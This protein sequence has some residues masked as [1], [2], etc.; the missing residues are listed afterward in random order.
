[1]IKKILKKASRLL[2]DK[3]FVGL[4]Y[5]LKFGEKMPWKNPV[6]FNQKLQWL[7]IY[8][9]N[10]EHCR[11]V[12]KYEAKLY[13]AERIGEEYIIPTYGVWDSF[14]EID[15]ASLPNQ[16]VLKCTHDCGSVFVCTDKSKFD[17]EAAKKKLTKAIGRNYYWG[18]REWAYK[19]V[20]PRI[21]AEKYMVDEKTA[22]LR[23]YKFFSFDGEAKML[24]I[25]TGRLSGEEVKFDFFDMDGKHLPIKNGHPNAKEIPELPKSFDKMKELA[26]VLSKGH[27]HIR[28]DFYEIN[29]EIYFGELTF[30]HFGGFV[31]FEP[32]EW[33]R[34]MGEWI[35]PLTFE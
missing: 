18:E 7:K 20:K 10:P 14:D 28:V 8:N 12:D 31:R 25:A 19:S 23:D 4:K 29:G 34:I 2:P 6:T 9:R 33:D 35:K 3:T 30:F 15:F 1:M 5:R 32:A 24:F 21:I 26:G 16:F 17:F 13:V 11:M 27:P 22:E